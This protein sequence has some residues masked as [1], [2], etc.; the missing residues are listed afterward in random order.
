MFL[1]FSFETNEGK[2]EA[3]EKCQLTY[4]LG[5]LIVL[6][7]SRRV[8]LALLTRLALAFTFFTIEIREK[9]N[10]CYAG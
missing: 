9:N 3:S 4:E 2:F 5:K 1:C 8:C 7:L 10:A 6:R